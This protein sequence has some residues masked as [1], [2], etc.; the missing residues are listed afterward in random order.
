V[1]EIDLS[2]LPSFRTMAWVIGL[3]LGGAL[4]G[5]VVQL[6]KWRRID[7][8]GTCRRADDEAGLSEAEIRNGKRGFHISIHHENKTWSPRDVEFDILGMH[9]KQKD[10]GKKRSLFVDEIARPRMEAGEKFLTLV[11]APK[12]CTDPEQAEVTYSPIHIAVWNHCFGWARKIE[13]HTSPVT[14]APFED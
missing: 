10:R 3:V 1:T 8:I 6:R 4:G 12:G 5:K 14:L 7:W 11:T 2:F 9:R 13:R